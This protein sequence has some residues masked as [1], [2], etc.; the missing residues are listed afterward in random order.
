MKRHFTQEEMQMS[1]KLYFISV[2]KK[3]DTLSFLLDWQKLKP[4]LI[5]NISENM[6]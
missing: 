4:L 1:Y 2:I 5:S 3:P 6:S